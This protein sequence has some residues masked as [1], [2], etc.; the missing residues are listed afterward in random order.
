M[1]IS[2]KYKFIFFKTYRCATESFESTIIPYLGKSDYVSLKTRDMERKIKF[3]RNSINLLSLLKKKFNEKILIERSIKNLI[4]NI[5]YLIKFDFNFVKIINLSDVFDEHENIKS[6]KSK[7]KSS[8]FDSYYKFTIYRPFSEV[9]I[10]HYKKFSDK[11][12]INQI[13]FK[14]YFFKNYK[15]IF[16]MQLK[17][18]SYRNK[19]LVDRIYKYQNLDK[20]SKNFL[21]K[22][23]LKKNYKY[24]LKAKLNKSAARKIFLTKEM[25]EKIKLLEQNSV[26]NSNQFKKKLF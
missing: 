15:K 16:K 2:K 14:E 3:K 6:V 24:F 13:Y 18:F 1:I 21:N 17:I 9:I 7:L 12:D 10:S 5:I 11:K 26:I 20:F 25:K 19:I 23:K 4:W 8:I 22:I